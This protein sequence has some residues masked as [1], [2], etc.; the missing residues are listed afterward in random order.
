MKVLV[1]V[2]GSKSS[3]QSVHAALDFTKKAE[4]GVCLLTVVRPIVDFDYELSASQREAVMKT[5]MQHAEEVIEKAKEVFVAGG[6]NP[7]CVIKTNANSVADEICDLVE[8]EKF[9]LVIMGRKGLKRTERAIMGSVTSRVIKCSPA[10]VLV[11]PS[12]A[13]LKW[14]RIL[15]AVDD[16]KCGEVAAQVALDMASAFGQ[17]LKVISVVDMPEETYSVIPNAIAKL[18]DSARS[19]ADSVKSRAEALNIKT[20]I[21]IKEGD[22]AWIITDFAEKENVDLICIGSYG[23]TGPNRF[24]VGSVAEKIIGG[25]L[26][27]IL[28]VKC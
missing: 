27:P 8:K 22:T 25:A 6:V 7:Y 26:C 5:L 21:Y 14:R 2:D 4:A 19:V 20:D 17:E 3:M 16:S 15:L 28:V 13:V 18:V 10:N 1:P 12:D 11:M 9:D 23:K 24:T